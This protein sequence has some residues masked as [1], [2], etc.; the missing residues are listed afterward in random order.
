MHK[1]PRLAEALKVLEAA[2]SIS[3]DA[4]EAV[5]QYHEMRAQGLIFEACRMVVDIV[6][7][8]N[9]LMS[10]MGVVNG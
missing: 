4:K 5:E 9:H 10:T 2:S 3:P 6:D 7:H 1:R 8:H